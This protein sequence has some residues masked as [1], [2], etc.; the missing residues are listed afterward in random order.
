MGR[1]VMSKDYDDL[2]RKI[3]ADRRAQQRD[4]ENRE[5]VQKAF[6]GGQANR[7]WNGSHTAK[8]TSNRK[9]GKKTEKAKGGCAFIV[10]AT[11][12]GVGGLVAAGATMRGWI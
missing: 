12:A 4:R 3:A 11:V 2:Q 10:M 1:D 8:K 5:D 7:D 9:G 6:A